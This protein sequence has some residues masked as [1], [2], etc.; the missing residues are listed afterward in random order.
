L[1]LLVAL[2]L[3]GAREVCAMIDQ[4]KLTE[5]DEAIN[6]IKT[7][8]DEILALD[9]SNFPVDL[10]KTFKDTFSEMRTA[11]TAFN[12]GQFD[13]GRWLRSTILGG[14][15]ECI[16]KGQLTPARKTQLVTLRSVF[17]EHFD[18]LFGEGVIE[19]KN[20]LI[21]VMT[22]ETAFLIGIAA[23]ESGRGAAIRKEWEKE[24]T[25]AARETRRADA[26]Q[27]IIETEAH[28][29]W[30]R[31]PEKIGKLTD[32][33]RGIFRKV[34]KRLS[35]VKTIP[36]SWRFG[37]TEEEITRG[38]GSIRKRLAKVNRQDQ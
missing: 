1:H 38:I 24:R 31:R 37:L 17:L 2:A 32:T 20:R 3:K 10:A 25:R 14:A 15:D 33:A 11:F 5:I 35:D 23:G 34:S 16:N 9:M 36:K 26:V 22:V 27:R 12:W 6:N 29:F 7:N 13:P 19:N 28:A 18:R 8:I 4:E 21:T 30:Q